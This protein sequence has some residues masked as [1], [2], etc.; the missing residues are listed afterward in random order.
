[1]SKVNE[2]LAQLDSA[3]DAAEARAAELAAI[4]ATAATALAKEQ[5]ALDALKAKHAALIA[6][7][8]AATHDARVALDRLRGQVNERVGALTG[9]G[10][11]PRV[12]V[13]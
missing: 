6:K 1:M 8:E 10:A 12:S 5:A 13:R 3:F 9:V 2:L 7:A 4:R 11:D